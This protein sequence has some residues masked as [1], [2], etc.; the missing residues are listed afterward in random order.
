MTPGVAG[1]HGDTGPLGAAGAGAGLVL[2]LM[3]TVLQ[4]APSG[5]LFLAPRAGGYF[6]LWLPTCQASHFPCNALVLGSPQVSDPRLPLPP[7]PDAPGQ[8]GAAAVH[9]ARFATIP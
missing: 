3:G 7:T 4:A 2:T 9:H 8:H 1:A 5:H 6:W